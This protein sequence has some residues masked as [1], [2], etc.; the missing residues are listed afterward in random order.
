MATIVDDMDQQPRFG[1]VD[2]QLF[3]NNRTIPPAT[4]TVPDNIFPSCA[5]PAGGGGSKG[6]FIIPYIGGLPH[7]GT[8][9]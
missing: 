2:F 5:V 8:N 1:T 7:S 9:R 6:H 3:A 4:V